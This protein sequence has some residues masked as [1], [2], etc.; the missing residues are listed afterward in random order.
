[1]DPSASSTACRQARRLFRRHRQAGH[2]RQTGFSDSSPQ[3]RAKLSTSEYRCRDGSRP[4]P[5]SGRSLR[6]Q[7]LPGGDHL[8]GF[9]QACPRT[10]GFGMRW[11]NLL[12]RGSRRAAR[13]AGPYTF[14]YQTDRVV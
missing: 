3:W 14:C 1:M 8:P 12:A 6:S 10:A 9:I 11:H 4:F 5:F 13:V 7:R 2:R